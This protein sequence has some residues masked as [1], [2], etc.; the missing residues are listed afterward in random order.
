MIKLKEKGVFMGCYF[1]GENPSKAMENKA[2]RGWQCS[3][4]YLFTCCL[5]SEVSSLTV[6]LSVCLSVEMQKMV[7][8]GKVIAP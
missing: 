7:I 5:A 6:T 2:V 8:A 4:Q 1:P 3:D